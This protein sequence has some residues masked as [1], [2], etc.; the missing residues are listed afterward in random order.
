M[1]GSRATATFEVSAAAGAPDP[2]LLAL[3][4]GR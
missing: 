4:R 1:R 3:V 2:E